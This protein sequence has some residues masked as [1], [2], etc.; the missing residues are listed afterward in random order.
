MSSGTTAL[1]SLA[2]SY[3]FE[4]SREAARYYQRVYDA[5]AA[6][7]DR[8]AAARTCQCARRIYLESGNVA[9]AEQWYKTG[10][11]MA[12]RFPGLPSAQECAVGNALAQ[13]AGAHRGA[14]RPD[15]GG[16]GT[17]RRRESPVD[18]GGNEGQRVLPLPARL[19]LVSFFG[20]DYKRAV[21]E[22]TKGDLTD[23]FVLA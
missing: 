17:C 13:R 23:P 21:D 8:G 5:G 6:A 22:L 10:Y 12:R 18:R 3:A 15:Q 4:S 2:V 9:K 16:A 14:S 20:K 19:H 7:D 11:E 1:T